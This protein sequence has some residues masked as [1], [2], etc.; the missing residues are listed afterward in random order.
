[1]IAGE[2]MQ[3]SQEVPVPQKQSTRKRYGRAVFYLGLSILL[4]VFILSLSMLIVS[5]YSGV[6]TSISGFSPFALLFTVI[7]ILL[8]IAGIVAIILPEG[9][10]N[11][12]VWIMKLGPFAG[13]N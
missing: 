9:L 10:T 3:S 13:N 1:M 6:E 11:D 2:Y 7:G 5:S 4:V 8:I 12:G